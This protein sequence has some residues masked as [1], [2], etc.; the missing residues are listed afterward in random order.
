[1]PRRFT[2]DTLIIASH[3]RNKAKEI[4][5]LLGQHIKNF[6][7]AGDLNLPEPEE[8]GTSFAE[9]A[10]LK[11][12]ASAKGANLP[13]LADD[14]GMCVNALNGDPGIYSARW[15]G[16][17]RDFNLAM[18]LVNE[19]LGDAADRSASFNSTLALAWPDG[20]VEVFEGVLNGTLIWPPRGDNGFGYDPMFIP[21]GHSRTFGEIDPAEKHRISHRA[22]AFAALVKGC[23]TA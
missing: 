20:H 8:T 4:A 18:R 14:S 19:K 17:K 5:D 12:L 7:L 13:A 1:M 10:I 2:G 3:N 22:K 16:E 11:A 15:G 23:F 21:E 6:P 9:N